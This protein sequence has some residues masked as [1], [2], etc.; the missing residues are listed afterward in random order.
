MA[1]SP[2]SGDMFLARRF[3][4][5]GLPSE[6]NSDALSYSGLRA[7]L[8]DENAAALVTKIGVLATVHGL[9]SLGI[10]LHHAVDRILQSLTPDERRTMAQ[11]G[12]VPPRV[13]AIMNAEAETA[14]A[15]QK[16]ASTNP[17]GTS[18]NGQNHGPNALGSNANMAMSMRGSGGERA[19]GASEA[20]GTAA[21]ISF[22]SSSL[23][24][25]GLTIDTFNAMQKE[26]FN[27]T[28]IKAAV[29]ANNSLGLEANDNPAATARLQRDT[30]WAVKS[31]Q[32][33]HGELKKAHDLDQKAKDAEARGDT[34][35][36]DHCRQQA[37]TIRQGEQERHHHTQDR[38][39]RERPERLPDYND[40]YRRMND[41]IEGLSHGDPQQ[42][43]ANRA[44]I[45]NYRRNPND[46]AASRQYEDLKKKASADP[47]TRSAMQ[48]IDK[49]VR[50][51]QQAKAAEEKRNEVAVAESKEIQKDF[52][53]LR[54]GNTDMFAAMLSAAPSKTASNEAP[55]T[56]PEA[57]S[58]PKPIK[59]A[60]SEVGSTKS[61]PA[62]TS[63]A[64]AAPATATKPA[65]APPI[66]K[67]RLAGSLNPTA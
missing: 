28:Q 33:S 24:K 37:A 44:A 13:E 41:A 46:A 22:A 14:K 6:R 4:F 67:T 62:K 27:T 5:V 49:T 20:R 9:E 45:E 42:E 3:N 12:A 34:A 25:T 11:G 23:A 58:D 30:P 29:T 32:G 63:D 21:E 56:Q 19:S 52:A 47:R 36:A 53:E 17:D 48:T 15:Q 2:T 18:R 8:G 35:A 66:Q 54:G 26:G 60:P 50:Q 39:R 1:N 40:R 31:L 57:H 43:K 55:A 10:P 64:K 59:T 51:G 38:M 65:A 16:Q 61:D 7:E